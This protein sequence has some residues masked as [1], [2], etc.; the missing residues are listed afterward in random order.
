M[1][2]IDKTYYTQMLNKERLIPF[3][4]NNRL[5]C[6]I[7]FYICDLKQKNAYLRDNMWSVENDNLEGNCC[8][9]DQLWTDKNSDNPR[10]SY[11]I[12]NKFKT[13]IKQNFPNVRYYTFNRYKHKK[14]YKHIIERS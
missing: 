14:V 6:F 5:I 4:I 13:Y 2:I 1:K 11:Q 7:T 3:I 9:I 8:Y 12:W 10:L